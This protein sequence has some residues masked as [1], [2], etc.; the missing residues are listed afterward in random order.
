MSR[1]SLDQRDLRRAFGRFATGVTVVTASLPTEEKIGFT[2]NSFASVS[3]EPPL[4]SWNCRRSARNLGA[5]LNARHFA[6]NV[7]ADDQQALSRQFADPSSDRF[8]G[9]TTQPGVGG[10]P[11]IAGCIAN[12]ECERWSTVEAG[13]HIIFIGKVLRYAYTE[14]PPLI[15]LNGSYVSCAAPQVA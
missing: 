7:L 6:V 2:V 1:E 15:F 13:D 9:V 10:V 4:I 5:F 11:L 12:F 14:Q 3:I 8:T